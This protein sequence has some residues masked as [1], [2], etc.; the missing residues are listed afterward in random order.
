MCGIVGIINLKNKSIDTSSIHL[1]MDKIAHRGPDDQG[2][3]VE[4]NFGLGHVRLSILDL[5]SAGHQPMFSNNSRYGIIFNGEIYNYLELKEELKNDY[6]FITKTDTEVILAAYQKWGKKCLDKFNGDW[7]F[8]IYDKLK[9]SFFGARDR[10]GIKPLYYTQY[11]DNLIFSSEIKSIIPLIK[12]RYVNKK[13]IYEYLVYNRTD[14]SNETFF[15]DIFKLKHGHY[16]T[17]K[18]NSFSVDRW[19]NLSD[20]INSVLMTPQEYRQELRNSVKLRLRSDVPIGVSLSGG[21]DSSTITSIV[22]SDFGLKDVKTFSAVYN[23]SWADESSFINEYKTV[24]NNMFF[25]SPTADTFYKDFQ[26]FIY[27]QGEPVASIG[28]YAQYKVMELAKGNIVVSLDGQGADEQLGGYHYFFGSYF[29]ELFMTLRFLKLT[30]ELFYYLKTHKSTYALKYMMFYLAPKMIQDQIGNKIFGS[31]NKDFFYEYKD[32]SG[33][34]KD[35]YNPKSLNKSLVEHFEYKLEHLLKWDDLNSMNFSIESRVPFM[36]HNLVEKTLSLPADMKINRSTTKFILRESVK[37]IL[38]NKIYNRIDKKGFSTP[39]D[40]WFRSLKFRNYINDMLNSNSFN[41][42]NFFD[43]ED[44][45]RKY[46][47]HLSLNGNMTKDI[48]KWI[49]IYEWHS[50]FINN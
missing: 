43:V 33:I 5:S 20:N 35:L 45:K 28:P 38:P 30:S 10:Y 8:V 7:A 29:K 41:N 22:F 4:K 49:N 36:D 15:K 34:S 18:D 27:A 6:K 32:V 46:K 17:V 42:L 9:N 3:F 1:M 19:Y 14:Q 2:V 21:I 12:D 24:L 25:T 48:W 50:K 23:D 44:C 13:I 31:I 26:Q 40:N 16:F 39:S 11:N 37:D 47:D